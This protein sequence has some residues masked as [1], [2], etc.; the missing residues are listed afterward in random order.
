MDNAQR[1]AKRIVTVTKDGRTEDFEV[2]GETTLSALV[3]AVHDRYQVS[4]LV[5]VR[6]SYVQR[7][8]PAGQHIHIDGDNHLATF[9][10]LPEGDVLGPL[11]AKNVHHEVVFVKLGFHPSY[12]IFTFPHWPPADLSTVFAAAKERFSPAFDT[13]T[14]PELHLLE[15]GHF[16]RISKD[17]EWRQFG[18]PLLKN[19]G[20]L[21]D[22]AAFH[23]GPLKHA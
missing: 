20:L 22:T 21:G 23:V 11:M 14:S 8:F 16:T 2:D 3:E 18:W 1:E 19:K 17:W 9:L 7:Y 12:E 10:S 15:H 6:F 13:C 4:P 5:K